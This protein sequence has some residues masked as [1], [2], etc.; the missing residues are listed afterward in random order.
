VQIDP[1]QRNKIHTF[2]GYVIYFFI[3]FTG[4]QCS[5][6]YD[7]H[8][9]PPLVLQS[10]FVNFTSPIQQIQGKEALLS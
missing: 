3:R 9:K 5:K 2:A 1:L 8:I 7:S 4:I 10:R 6:T